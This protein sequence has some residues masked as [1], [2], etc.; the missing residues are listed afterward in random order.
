LTASVED[1]H[2]IFLLYGLIIHVVVKQLLT[3]LTKLL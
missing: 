1:M 2:C 3:N